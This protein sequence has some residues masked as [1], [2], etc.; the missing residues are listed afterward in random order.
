ML[1][2]TGTHLT[3]VGVDYYCYYYHYYYYC[4]HHY[5]RPT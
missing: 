2:E 5:H 1:A 3:K 4:H